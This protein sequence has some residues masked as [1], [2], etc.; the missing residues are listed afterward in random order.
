MAV[1]VNG[2]N[3]EVMN[4]LANKIAGILKTIPGAADVKVEQTTG[5]PVLDFKLNRV[6]WHG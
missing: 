6:I 4:K 3:F 5:L 1:K 2:D